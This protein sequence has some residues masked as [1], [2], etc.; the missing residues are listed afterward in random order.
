M[1]VPDLCC[2]KTSAHHGTSWESSETNRT[3]PPSL[4]GTSASGVSPTLG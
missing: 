3:A 1:S 2:D 4:S